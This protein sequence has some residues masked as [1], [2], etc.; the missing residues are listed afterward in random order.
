MYYLENNQY[1]QNEVDNVYESMCESV[2]VE[3]N[4]KLDSKTITLH[5]GLSNKRRMICKPWWTNQLLELWNNVCD[6]EGR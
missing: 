4:D 5:S 1:D 2:K 3:M 6:V